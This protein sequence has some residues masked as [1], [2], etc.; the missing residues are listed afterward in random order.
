MSKTFG[1]TRALAS[2]SL[3]VAS[4]SIHAL[5]GL[6]G[7]GKSTLV[8]TLAGYHDADEGAITMGEV[9]FV[10]QDLGLLPTLTVLE[11]FA[12]GRPM[13]MKHGRI[14]W[15][16]EAE[17]ATAALDEFGLRHTLHE[18]VQSLP[19][20]QQAIIACARALDRSSS[21]AVEALV[22]DEPT[23]ALPSSDIGLLADAMT[24]YAARGIGIVFITH[25]LQEVKDLADTVTVLRNGEV[26]FSGATAGLTIPDMVQLMVGSAPA[27]V[28]A[29]W[30]APPRTG[31]PT[32]SAHDVRTQTI[33]D[34]SLDIHGGEIVGVFGMVGSGLDE[35][36]AIM[37][38]RNAP[39]AGRVELAGEVLRANSPRSREIGFVPSDRPRRGVLPG[40]TV[41]DNI[42]VRSLRRTIRL[43]SIAKKRERKLAGFWT[44]ELSVK[45]SDPE[46]PMLTLSGGNQQK[47]ILGRWLAI[48]PPAIIAEEPTQGIDVWAKQ[49]ILRRLRMAAESGTAVLLTAV[50]PEEILDFCDRVVVLRAGK[51]ALDAE[52]SQVHVTD[53][54]SA[55]H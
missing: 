24:T 20:A 2:V 7:S 35:L 54:L 44:Q 6:N 34:L 14:D 40:L 5:I 15:D 17:R 51:V 22:L 42:S 18:Q 52:R 26:V 8:K 19:L 50:E 33:N 45:P 41:R 13:A 28:E 1:A 32:L 10:H 49:D 12:I 46:A 16:A 25:R 9:A 37:S 39:S 23:S 11:N 55:M 53:I 31:V 21:G 3:E 43:G 47:A 48:D 30:T 4:G 38:G 29:T 36:G 27:H